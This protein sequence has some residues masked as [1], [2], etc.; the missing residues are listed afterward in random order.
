[1]SM[2]FAFLVIT[3]TGYIGSAFF[4]APLISSLET[5]IFRIPIINILYSYIKES[6]F[7]FIEKLDKPVMVKIR[8]QDC[9][10]YKLGFLTQEKLHALSLHEGEVAVYLPHAYAF[11][12]EVTIFPKKDVKLLDIPSTDVLRLILTGGL[13]EI[14]RPLMSAEKKR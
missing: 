12:G 2:V 7:A 9:E 3:I 4:V 8:N 10:V 14:K 13:A 11:S 6:T 1:M 5:V